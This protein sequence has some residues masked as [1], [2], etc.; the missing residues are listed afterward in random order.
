M[1]P[2][3]AGTAKAIGLACLFLLCQCSAPSDP[4]KPPTIACSELRQDAMHQLPFGVQDAEGT[5]KWITETYGVNSRAVSAETYSDGQTSLAWSAD[6][7]RHLAWFRQEKLTSVETRW[8][9]RQPTIGDALRCLDQPE[10]YHAE[11][12]LPPEARELDFGMW[13]PAKGTAVFA[14]QISNESEPPAITR[15]MKVTVMVVTAPGR[16][17]EVVTSG[18]ALGYASGVRDAVLQTMKPWPGSV[19]RVEVHDAR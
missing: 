15:E 3:S 10:L 4:T 2:S 14:S 6:G 7:A 8:Q 11:Y 9:L 16:A 13:Y 18:Y 12:R 5:V 1:R 17:E 19:E